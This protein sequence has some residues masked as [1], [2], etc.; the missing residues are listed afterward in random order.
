MSAVP[1]TAV[2][3]QTSRVVRVGPPPDIRPTG[4]TGP[5]LNSKNVGVS[6]SNL[7]GRAIQAFC[8]RLFSNHGVAQPAG[9]SRMEPA[10]LQW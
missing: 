7:F 2:R 4:V 3:K 8:P 1:L 10:L 5:T 6:S 9:C